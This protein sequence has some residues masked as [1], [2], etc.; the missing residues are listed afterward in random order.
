M[1][2]ISCGF[3]AFL[4]VLAAPSAR[5]QIRMIGYA[6][7]EEEMSMFASAMAAQMQGAMSAGP[8]GSGGV[9]A[10]PSA[11]LQAL[12]KLEFD[13]RASTQLSVWATPPKKPEEHKPAAEAPEAPATEAPMPSEAPSGTSAAASSSDITFSRRLRSRSPSFFLRSR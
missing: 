1:R 13:R 2:L 6:D 12:Q 11:R 5:G 9:N 10:P 7:G 3:A 8:E 4:F